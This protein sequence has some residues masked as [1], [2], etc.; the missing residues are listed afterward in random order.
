MKYIFLVLGFVVFFNNASV[1]A[2]S[3]VTV[4]CGQQLELQGVSTPTDLAGCTVIPT[5]A[6]PPALSTFGQN[7][8]SSWVVTPVG[9]QPPINRTTTSNVNYQMS[10]PNGTQTVSSNTVSVTFEACT[11]SGGGYTLSAAP[12][13]VQICSPATQGS[14]A[15]SWTTENPSDY[16]YVYVNGAPSLVG[17][18]NQTQ[19]VSW[20]QPGQSY[21][22]TLRRASAPDVVVAGPVVVTGT[23]NGCT[24]TG[25]GYCG[26]SSVQAPNSLGVNETCDAGA[27]NGQPGSSCS[28]TCQDV[29]AGPVCGN[30]VQEIGEQCDLG[31]AQNGQS[32]SACSASCQNQ[33][34]GTSQYYACATT[35]TSCEPVPNSSQY[36]TATECSNAIGRQCRTT[37]NCDNVCTGTPPPTVLSYICNTPNSGQTCATRVG[38]SCTPA[39][40]ASGRCFNN[41]TS[42][43]PALCAA[44]CGSQRYTCGGTDCI[45][46]G[47]EGQSTCPSGP[48]TFTSL[49]QCQSSLVCQNNPSCSFIASPSS[50]TV[51]STVNLSLDSGGAQSC[52]YNTV[53][54]V[55]GGNTGTSYNGPSGQLVSGANSFNATC[56]F[57]GG[58]MVSCISNTV[59]GTAAIPPSVSCTPSVATSLPATFTYTASNFT[60]APTCT[61]NGVPNTSGTFTRTTAGDSTVRCTSGAQTAEATCQAQ[62]ACAS[63]VC[64]V[65][66]PQNCNSDASLCVGATIIDPTNQRVLSGRP[67]TVSFRFQ[68]IGNTT[69]T[70]PTYQVRTTSG[71]YGPWATVFGVRALSPSPLA[72][73]LGGSGTTNSYSQ[74]FTAPTVSSQTSYTLGF[75]VAKSGVGISSQCLV[76]GNPQVVVNV[77]QC[78]DKIDNDGDGTIDC[79][80]TD[81]NG[82]TVPAD[83]GCFPNGNGGGG[84]CDVNDDDETNNTGANMSIVANP[85]LVR[86]NG[87]SNVTFTCDAGTWSVTGPQVN[88]ITGISRDTTSVGCNISNVFCGTSAVTDKVFPAQNIQTKE[89]YTLRCGGRERSATIS[90]IKIN[91]I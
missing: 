16:M 57:G 18:G 48:T 29:N 67:F 53:P 62:D 3:T 40:L 82:N 77:P 7:A 68:N 60:S 4:P 43:A 27:Q 84:A 35:G 75:E 66:C 69:W 1:Y 19:S 56:D 50:G 32:G 81:K 6:T 58:N 45:P 63:G 31:S 73:T 91:E 39:E 86:Q 78:N 8:N 23:S 88:N 79:G 37:S 83:P 65:S 5:S 26:D 47:V 25:T 22:F 2:Q 10:C 46:C 71:T 28:A 14:T 76:N 24:T 20:I 13:P 74:E 41:S 36:A 64:N 30:G 34:P 61:V 49:F 12:N 38:Q 89:T 52:T 54:N 33:T 21:S 80:I 51:G 90:V 15:I 87:N 9:R 85:Q 72:G 55:S 17:T 59:T 44:V 70:S 42:N 11:P